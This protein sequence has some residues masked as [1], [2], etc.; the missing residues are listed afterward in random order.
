MVRQI[1]DMQNY[2][3]VVKTSLE[4]APKDHEMSAAIILAYH[5]KTD[6]TFLRPQASRTPDLYI[7]GIKWEVKSPIGQGKRTIDNNFSEARRQSNNIVIDLRRIKM[8]QSKA[9]ARMRFYL[10]TP[11]HFK[12]VIVITKSKKVVVIL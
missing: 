6:V 5:F 2:R 1:K 12:R 11:H 8:H 7:N 9:D 3:V 4:D 10:S